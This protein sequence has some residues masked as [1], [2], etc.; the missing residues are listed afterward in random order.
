MINIVS[1]TFLISVIVGILLIFS[2]CADTKEQGVKKINEYSVNIPENC[3]LSKQEVFSNA[4]VVTLSDTTW[5]Y[6]YNHLNDT[7]YMI[8]IKNNNAIKKFGFR[9][10]DYGFEAKDMIECRIHSQNCVSFFSY[11]DQKIAFVDLLGNKDSVQILNMENYLQSNEEV[12]SY[13]ARKYILQRNKLHFIKAYTDILLDSPDAFKKYFS[14]KQNIVFNFNQDTSTTSYLKFPEKYRNSKYYG[15]LDYYMAPYN[16]KILYSFTV[17][18]SLFIYKKDSLVKK[19]Y[20]G[21]NQDP[22]FNPFPMEKLRDKSA[23]KKYMLCE[24]RYDRL[25]IDSINNCIYRV[26]KYRHENCDEMLPRREE[27]KFSLIKLNSDYSKSGEYKVDSSLYTVGIIHSMKEGLL[28]SNS[29]KSSPDDR[30]SLSYV[31]L[32]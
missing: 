19:V 21:S 9:Y 20:A 24:P 18:D 16:D 32:Y 6:F 12:F 2:S 28:L 22:V 5:F 27:I 8:D 14:R 1:K 25:I 11:K 26:Y 15:E 30:I 10:R 31:E 13:N 3:D 7:L 4:H 17:C 29:L 23:S